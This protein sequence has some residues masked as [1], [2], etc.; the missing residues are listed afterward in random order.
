MAKNT[1]N[2]NSNSTDK[3]ASSHYKLNTKAI[4]RLLNADK[5]EIPS[6]K[7]LKDP[8]KKYRSGF[9][10][11][12]P[13]TVKA[14]FVKFWFG[15]AVCYFILWGLG[16]YVT[17]M[18]DMIVLL[19]VVLGM[20]TDLL[21]NNVLRLVETIPHANDK[22]MMFTKKKLWTFFANIPYSALILVCV[23]WLYT[24]INTVIG[25]IIGKPDTITLG[26]EPIFFGIFYM[27]FDLLF[28]CMKR[29]VIKIINDAKDKVDKQ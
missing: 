2:P 24:A 13:D 20:I 18:L 11:R 28:I 1:R 16:I 23:I 26:V 27:L 29:L 22:W 17:D 5:M 25:A 8:A 15:G 3:D 7:K 19:S 9:L 4:D 21:T 12:I 10:D 14:L 6:D